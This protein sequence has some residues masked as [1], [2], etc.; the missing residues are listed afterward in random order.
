M[1]R[2]QTHLADSRTNRP[3]AIPGGFIL[4]VNHAVKS[5]WRLHLV[6]VII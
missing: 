4:M 2:T 5:R 6:C 3:G 1:V